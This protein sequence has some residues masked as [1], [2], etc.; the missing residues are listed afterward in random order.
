MYIYPQMYMLR[1]R[2][3]L[4]SHST[5]VSVIHIKELTEISE[6]SKIIAKESRQ[7]SANKQR[8]FSSE[9]RQQ[10]SL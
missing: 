8:S 9:D 4:S 1:E 6:Y 5:T 10:I 7:M 2:Y 3:D